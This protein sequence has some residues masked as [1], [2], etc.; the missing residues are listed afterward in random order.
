MLKLENVDAG[1]GKLGI[2]WDVS[3][4]VKEG[5][6]VALV[7]PNGAGKT[8]TLRAISNI[9]TPTKGKITFD[10]KEITKLSVQEITKAGLSYITDDGA[11]FSGMTVQQNLKMGCLLYTSGLWCHEDTELCSWRVL[12][13][14]R[15]LCICGAFHVG[16][17]WY[18]C[19]RSGS[20]DGFCVWGNYRAVD[21]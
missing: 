19:P 14:R 9:I 15:V 21:I 11:L 8:T 13:D 4:E 6:F 10:G 20:S 18:C 17:S 16:T 2:L 7:G 12:S 5:E 3:L 1:Y